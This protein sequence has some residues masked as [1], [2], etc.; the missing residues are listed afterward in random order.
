[1]EKVGYSGGERGV[2]VWSPLTRG[3]RYDKNIT[4]FFFFYIPIHD[5]ITLLCHVGF[6]FCKLF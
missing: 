3:G 4:I 5:L 6:Y 2:W 1:M